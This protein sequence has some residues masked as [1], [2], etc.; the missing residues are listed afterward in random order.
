VK[1]YDFKAGQMQKDDELVVIG[2]KEWG[3]SPKQ[4]LKYLA[5]RYGGFL[6]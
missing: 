4:I 5:L 2:E 6:L 1:S 3:R